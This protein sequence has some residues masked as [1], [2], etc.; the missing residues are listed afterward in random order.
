MN[1]FDFSRQ[2]RLLTAGDYRRVFDK[3]DFKVSDQHLLILA[4]PAQT[5]HS[6]LGLVIAKKH[7]KRAVDRNRIKRTL[8]ESFRTLEHPLQ[9]PVDIVVLARKGL[10]EMEKPLL[11]KL[12]NKQWRRLAKKMQQSPQK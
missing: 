3:A 10:G 6:R 9:P 11:H 8:R 12:F 5:P 2:R 7:V 1:E 4:R